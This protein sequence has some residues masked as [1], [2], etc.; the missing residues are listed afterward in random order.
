MPAPVSRPSR[1]FRK[2]WGYVAAST[3]AATVLVLIGLR[4]LGPWG[5]TER[6]RGRDDISILV[7]SPVGEVTVP[8]E[9]RWK[10]VAGVVSYEARIHNAAGDLF[11]QSSVKETHAVLPDHI[12]NSL[13][14]GDTYFW[15]V[16]AETAEGDPLKSDVIGFTVRR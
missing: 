8:S 6:L 11:W 12:R 13:K 14:P 10:P 15:Q 5:E 9:L 3:V 4:L 2:T 7:L 16:E 1:F